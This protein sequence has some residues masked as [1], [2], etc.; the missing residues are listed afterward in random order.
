KLK[1]NL[2]RLLEREGFIAGFRVTPN[3]D[4]PGA[5]LKIDLKY[6]ED[7][8]KSII[9]I[10]RVSKPG[11]RIYKKSD[12]MPKV[13]GGVGVAVVSTSRGLMTDR[14]ARKARLGGEVLCYVW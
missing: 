13:L 4:K 12:Q 10:K 9:G 1:E 7:R 6:A 11:L 3:V 8:R 2:A 5:T 14:E